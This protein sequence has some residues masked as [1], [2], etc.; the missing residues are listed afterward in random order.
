M[1]QS[2]KW[3]L[4]NG[5]MVGSLKGSLP[6]S[7]LDHEREESKDRKKMDNVLTQHQMGQKIRGSFRGASKQGG[8][9]ASS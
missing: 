5:A 9:E 6:R 7:D 8:V 2:G 3:H 4:G 1:E